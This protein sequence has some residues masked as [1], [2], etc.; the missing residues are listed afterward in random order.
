LVKEL[1][2]SGLIVDPTDP[3]AMAKKAKDDANPIL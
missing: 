3:I 1:K 2:N